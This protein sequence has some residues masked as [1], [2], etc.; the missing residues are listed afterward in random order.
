MAMIFP[1][2]IMN[3]IRAAHRDGKPVNKGKTIF[4]GAFL[5]EPKTVPAP[6]SYK[7]GEVNVPARCSS[8]GEDL[9]EGSPV[10]GVTYDLYPGKEL[11][12]NTQHYLHLEPCQHAG[13]AAGPNTL[14]GKP[15]KS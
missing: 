12:E 4:P 13:W 5:D 10:I 8:C 1:K 3:A 15:V 11:S 9:P 7:I 14:D 2:G 6:G